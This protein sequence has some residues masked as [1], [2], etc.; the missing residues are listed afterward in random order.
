MGPPGWKGGLTRVN[1]YLRQYAPDHPHAVNSY[2]AQHRL[3]MEKHIG[4]FLH[5]RER[6]HHKN[7]QRDDNRI[8]N[9][10]LWTLGRKDPHGVRVEDLLREMIHQHPELAEQIIK[11]RDPDA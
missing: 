2:V 9:L 11:E 6:V 3:I 1:G 5:P 4:R 8:E 7:G 10:E